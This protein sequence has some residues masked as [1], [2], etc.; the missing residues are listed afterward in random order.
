MKNH[1]IWF[2][3]ILALAALLAIGCTVLGIA[4]GILI[5]ALPFT[6]AGKGL[7]ALSLSGSTGNMAAIVLYGVLCL[8]PLLLKLRGKRTWKDLLLPVCSALLFYVLYGMINPACRPLILRNDAGTASMAGAVYSVLLCWGILSLTEACS[9]A[10][11]EKIYGTL[12][13]FL[14][15]CVAECV[16]GI[17]IG[18]GSC[19]ESIRSVKAANTMPGLSLAPTY[20]FMVLSFAMTVLEYGLDILLLAL[21]GKLLL[22]LQADAYSEHSFRASRVLSV[23]CRRSLI[24]LSLSGAA[25]NAAQIV[26]AGSLHYADV[27]VHFPVVG[28]A[29]SFGLLALTRLLLQGKELKD[30]NDLFI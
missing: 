25:L 8:L 12:R 5:L 13:I 6:L 4:D 15:L 3:A 20:L 23:W 26:F 28:L 27:V 29:L 10:G 24:L 11:T 14:L 9:E 21:A 17:L 18:L 2:F 19:L 1:L 7:R 16:V 22:Q 30:D